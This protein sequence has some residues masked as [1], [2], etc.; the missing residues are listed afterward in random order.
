MTFQA[1]HNDATQTDSAVKIK[2]QTLKQKLMTG[3]CCLA[4][5]YIA[6]LT[7]DFMGESLIL[8]PFPA[9]N[10]VHVHISVL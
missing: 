5:V 2:L 10:D 3:R 6:L 8:H 9:Y 1:E 4:S 7:Q